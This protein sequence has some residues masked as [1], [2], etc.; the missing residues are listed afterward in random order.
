MANKY[1]NGKI[2]KLIC[3]NGYYYIGS[4]IQKLNLRFNHHKGSAKT[5]TSTV[6]NYINNIGWD[7]VKIELIEDFPCSIKSELNKRED[8]YINLSKNDELCLNFNRAYVSDEERKENMK[9]YYEKNKETIIQN[10]REYNEKNKDKVD[11]YHAQYRLENAKKRREYSKQ[12]AQEH[13]EQVREAKKK[14][15]QEN[16]EKIKAQKAIY[17]KLYYQKR[18]EK[19]KS[20]KDEL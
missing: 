5:G 8:Y 15:N 13:P 19:I 7:K 14:Y 2:Y 17:N 3:D 16:K 6:Y 11:A 9:A 10:H 12:Y 1:E 20:E 18:K 4:T